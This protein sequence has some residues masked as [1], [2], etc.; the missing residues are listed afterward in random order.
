VAISPLSESGVPIERYSWLPLLPLPGKV[1]DKEWVTIIQ[2]PGGGPKQISIRSSRIVSLPKKAIPNVNLDHFIHYLTDTEPGSSG[3]PVVNDQWQVIALHHKAVPAPRMRGASDKPAVYIGN[4]GV[5]ISAIYKMLETH[6][7]ENDQVRRVLD[8]LDAAFGFAPISQAMPSGEEDAFEKDAKPYASARWKKAPGIGYDP[9]F[10][11]EP[12]DLQEIYASAKTSGLTA[13]LK[14][15][16]NDEL[17]YHRFSVIVH[18]ERKFALLTAVN[19]HGSQLKHPGKRQSV[20]RQDE[21]MDAVYQPAG[22]FYEKQKGTDKIQF[23][24][25]HLVR[26][27]DPSWGK[28]IEEAK[29]GD[30][31]SFHYAN[32]APQF[33]SYNDIDW[34]NLEDYVLDRAQTTEKKMTVFQGPIFRDDDP[35]YGKSRVG[36]PWRIPLSFWKIAVLEKAPGQ[37]A[38][39]AFMI[40]Q[41]K[42]VG[43]LY[44]AKVFSGLRPYRLDDMRSSKIQTTIK[45]IEDET[46]LD[47]SAIRAFDA[48]GSLE[49]TR[50]TRWI[51]RLSDVLI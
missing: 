11:S 41:T 43:A 29:R 30:E 17:T 9:N 6:R 31:D 16:T 45:T 12:I 25:G 15:G 26:R 49:S 42:Y 38:A 23:S 18:K 39:A 22:D 36:G 19:I 33:Q 10:L 50:Q 51:N 27:F 32:A 14:N 40:G 37:I 4:E 5:R 44:E 28:T 34:G 47:F 3:A 2:H 35:L 21:R 1:V 46:G 20:W 7:L 8:R 48:H 13:P 24:R